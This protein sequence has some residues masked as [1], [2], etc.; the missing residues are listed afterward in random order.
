[1]ADANAT[2]CYLNGLSLHTINEVEK[3]LLAL[4]KKGDRCEVQVTKPL[5][6][7]IGRSTGDV[8]ASKSMQIHDE[9]RPLSLSPPLQKS[10]KSSKSKKLSEYSCMSSTKEQMET[11][12]IRNGSNASAAKKLQCKVLTDQV[13]VSPIVSCNGVILELDVEVTIPD[14][15][16]KK[17]LK[18]EIECPDFVPARIKIGNKWKKIV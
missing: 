14:R 10:E 18:L 9:P 16:E 8:I 2:I 7:T 13:R 4:P 15:E 1:M 5:N 17:K 11:V 12:E 6:G 3:I